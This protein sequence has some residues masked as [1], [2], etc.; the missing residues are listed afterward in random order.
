MDRIYFDSPHDD[1]TRRRHL[2]AGA[3]YVYSPR[4]SLKALCDHARALIE[5]AFGGLDPR[6]AQHSL[7]VERYVEI[8]APLKPRFIHHPRTKELIR[9]ALVE[10]GCD[11][12]ETYQDVPR[13]RMVTS[14]G[15]LTSGVGYAH[16]P[17]RDTWYSA[18]LCQQN[19]WVPIY[20]F[21]AESGMAFHPRYWAQGVRNGSANFN[22]Y[23]WNAVGRRD[24]AKMIHGDTRKQPKAEEPLDALE[25]AVTLVVP[26]GGAIVFSAAQMHSTVANTTG[27]TRYS[28]DFRVCHL[29]DLRERRSAPNVDSQPR[30]TS[31]RDFLRARDLAPMPEDV[32]ALYDDASA[33]VGELVFRPQS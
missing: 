6:V 19:W 28:M 30:G 17:H 31:L 27:R 4:P 14:D 3:L 24:A 11:L 10:M 23:E 12:D 29:R 2:Y 13:L 21:E 8:C 22:Y 16:H 1:E 20:E 5:E 25:P 7:P 18:P 32:V 33:R 9:A 26:V 15:Y